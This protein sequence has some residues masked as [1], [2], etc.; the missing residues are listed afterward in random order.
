MKF[1]VGDKVHAVVLGTREATNEE[2]EV[3]YTKDKNGVLGAKIVDFT[4]REF[5]GEVL[6]VHQRKEGDG[7]YT[8]YK[9]T[10]PDGDRG[11]TLWVEER[12]L[13]AA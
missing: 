3:T 2:G 11:G 12:F 13:T 1:S 8:A 6:N 9:V 10:C 5:D 7:I 4:Q